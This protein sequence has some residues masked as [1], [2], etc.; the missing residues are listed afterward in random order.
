MAPWLD[1]LMLAL[2]LGGGWTGLLLLAQAGWRPFPAAIARAQQPRRQAAPAR[3]R[4]GRP[5]SD[6]SIASR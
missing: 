4:D 3:A 5:D 6:A 2:A 1:F